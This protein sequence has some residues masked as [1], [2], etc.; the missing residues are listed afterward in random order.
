MIHARVNG[1][2]FFGTVGADAILNFG[3]VEFALPGVGQSLVHVAG[4]DEGIGGLPGLRLVLEKS[5]FER[6][7]ILVLH[8]ED[9]D[10]ASVGFHEGAGI[11]VHGGEI[12]FGGAREAVSAEQFVGLESERAD[13]FGELAASGSAHEVE[14]PEAILRGDVTL[15]FDSVGERG[16]ANMGDAPVVALDGDFFL[17]AG[18]GKRAVKLRKRAIDEAP[19]D[20][21]EDDGEDENCPGEET[22]NLAQAIS[23]QREVKTEFKGGNAGAQP[24]GDGGQYEVGAAR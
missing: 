19:G 24:R 8:D 2:Q 18:E 7:I 5:E 22:K 17:D 23:G 4:N 20:C 3:A 6:Q 15:G 1:E 12:A 16:G 10:A 14:L 21:S 11:L 13:N 9:V